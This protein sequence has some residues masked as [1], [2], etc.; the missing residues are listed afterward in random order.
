MIISDID[1]QETLNQ[2]AEVEGGWLD[3]SL[4]QP[5]TQALQLFPAAS[6]GILNLGSGISTGNTAISFNFSMPM[7]FAI[8]MPTGNLSSMAGRGRWGGRNGG[9]SNSQNLLGAILLQAFLGGL[10]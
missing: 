8:N 1:Y 10:F 4:S 2:V 9:R 5:F 6:A 3:S 7:L